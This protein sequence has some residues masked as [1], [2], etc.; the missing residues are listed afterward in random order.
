MSAF[1]PFQW[2]SAISLEINFKAGASDNRLIKTWGCN[3]IGRVSVLQTE[4]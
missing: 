1:N 4:G 2:V 3:S